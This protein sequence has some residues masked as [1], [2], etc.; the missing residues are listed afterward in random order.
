MIKKIVVVGGLGFVGRRLVD[1]LIEVGHEV[2]V[3]DKDSDTSFLNPKAQFFKIDIND[4]VSI[5]SAFNKFKPHSVFHLA[6]IH[7]IPYCESNPSEVF[8]T[9]LG[10]LQNIIKASEEVCVSKFVFTSSA[11][12]YE[13]S[14]DPLTEKSNVTPVETYG[15]SKLFGEK[16]IQNSGLNYTTVRLFN[17]YGP[18]DKV[19]HVIPK[20]ISGI[21][22]KILIQLG[23]CSKARD[24]IFLDD[25]VSG[26]MII[27]NEETGLVINLGSGKSTTIKNIITSLEKITGSSINYTEDKTLFRKNDRDVLLCDN[28]MLKKY[29]WEPRSLDEGLALIILDT[30]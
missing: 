22:N 28:S 2:A 9:N 29:A 19:A 20:I 10:G 26:L 17:V 25:V 14:K 4:K 7:Y 5:F 21:K 1:K 30:N 6:A 15:F 8:A 27:E 18:G 3:I 13:I 24:F 12:V 16:L 11:A 23:D